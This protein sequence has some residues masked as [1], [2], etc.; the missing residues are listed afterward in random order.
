MSRRGNT[1]LLAQPST[2]VYFA[3]DALS[4]DWGYSSEKSSGKHV[5]EYFDGHLNIEIIPASGAAAWI[6]PEVGQE[7]GRAENS[8][9]LRRLT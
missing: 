2:R 7:D 9:N 1:S 5:T 8:A 3:P 4:T 6:P